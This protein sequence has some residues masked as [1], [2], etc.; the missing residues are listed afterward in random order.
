MSFPFKIDK[1]IILGKKKSKEQELLEVIRKWE[2]ISAREMLERCME[3]SNKLNRIADETQLPP[4]IIAS[5]MQA[6]ANDILA[7]PMN[8]AYIEAL[9]L[10][11]NYVD[12]NFIRKEQP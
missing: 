4:M 2:S 6:A 5:V 10:Y 1:V 11:K 9:Q 12:K 3:L 8:E 7:S